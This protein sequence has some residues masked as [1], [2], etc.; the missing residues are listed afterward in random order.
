MIATNNPIWMQDIYAGVMPAK[1]A[2]DT[3]PRFD[4][5]GNSDLDDSDYATIPP[6][7]LSIAQA[8]VRE[9]D[10]LRSDAKYMSASG[11]A[12]NSAIEGQYFT[13]IGDSL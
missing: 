12:Y 2:I 5:Y 8:F 7:E 6:S 10:K 9:A 4:E 3:T 1:S 13:R 11:E